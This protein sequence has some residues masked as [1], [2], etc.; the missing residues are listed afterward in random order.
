M[1]AYR[2]GGSQGRQY[3][4][5]LAEGYVAVRTRSRRSLDAS[6]ESKKGREVLAELEQV[7]RFY[8]AGVEVFRYG[9]NCRTAQARGAVR[10]ILK[11]QRD[12]QF[13]GRVLV[14]PRSKRPVLYTENVFVQFDA[15][16]A[17][18]ACRKL[19][20][21]YRLAMKRP[22][23]YAR[24]CFFVQAAEGTGR[25]VFDITDRLLQHKQVQLCHPELVRKM[26]W[27]Q[28][29][30]QQWHLKK[31]TIDGMVYDAHANVEAAW[32]LSQGEGIRIAVIDDGCDIDHEEL[33]GSGK[34]VA[35]RDV[36]RG[37]DNPRPGSRDNHGTACSGV[38]CANG[39]HGASGVA[40]KAQLIPIRYASPLGSQA[41]ADAFVW[42]ASHGADVISCSWGPEDGD[43]SDPSDPVHH[44]VVPLPDST[45][46]AID[47]A[48]ANGRNGK[49]CVITFAAG[50]GNESVDNDGY[51][52]YEKVIAVAACHAKGKKSAYSDFGNAVW[53]AFPSNDTLLP[54]PGI[55]TT[56]RSGAAGYNPGQTSRGDA[57]GNYVNDFGGTSSAC[58][59]TAGVAALI[60]GRNPSLRWDEVKDILK[61]SCDRIDV[62]G[63]NY[64]ALGHSPFYGYGRV[65][66]RRAVELAAPVVAVPTSTH[67]ASRVVPI[68]DLKTATISVTVG[69]VAAISAVTIGVDIEHTYI[70]DLIVKLAPPSS[71]RVGTIVLQHRQG[72]GTDN[73]KTT[74]D[75]VNTPSLAI[76]AGKNPQGRWRLLVEDKERVDEGQILQFSVSLS[77]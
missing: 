49:G 21:E 44:Q 3:K 48:I 23:E 43:W 62:A 18:S 10:S 14:D 72:D 13:A 1:L 28:V 19:L 35:P 39:Q 75:V 34:V 41:E 26:G 70:G 52:S 37:T 57:V 54:I 64:D 69:E 56:D 33:A 40:P 47:W 71:M 77:Y 60:L 27:R 63:G 67:T 32:T 74:Y 15:D 16:M 46:V 50:N 45:R 31:A 2:Y 73:L 17:E 22:I 42:A 38:A 9:A 11:D 51:A 76:L 29:F 30:P 59:G 65:N 7:T 66:A 20:K 25:T 68:R 12:V 8:D 61:R 58:P 24:N 36:T 6:L 55:W 4:L 53:C 5:E